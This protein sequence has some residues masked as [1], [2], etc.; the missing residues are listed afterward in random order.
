MVLGAPE[1]SAVSD[2]GGRRA[3]A[4]YD[5]DRQAQRRRPPSM[6]RRCPGALAGP[7]GQADPRASALELSERTARVAA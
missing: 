3:A 1:Q 5:R 4:I 2:E 6:A 7:S